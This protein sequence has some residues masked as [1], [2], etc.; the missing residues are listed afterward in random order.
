MP[1]PAD[2]LAAK[3]KFELADAA[4]RADIESAGPYSNDQRIRLIDELQLAADEYVERISRLRGQ[5][6]V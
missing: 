4:L 6:T 1:L 2:V 3:A 5:K